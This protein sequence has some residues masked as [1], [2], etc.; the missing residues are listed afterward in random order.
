MTAPVRRRMNESE[1]LRVHPLLLLLA[2]CGLAV[3]PQHLARPHSLHSAA[4]SLCIKM[5]CASPHHAQ[6]ASARPPD[7]LP[8]AHIMR[9]RTYPEK[10]ACSLSSSAPAPTSTSVVPT[11]L[12]NAAK[13]SGVVPALSMPLTC[14]PALRNPQRWLD[15]RTTR[16]CCRCSAATP[17]SDTTSPGGVPAPRRRRA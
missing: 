16:F 3:P 6:A 11:W 10:I 2:A 12:Y 8:A 7:P 15:C 14:A 9:S 13:A 1:S 17:L 5:W 4:Q